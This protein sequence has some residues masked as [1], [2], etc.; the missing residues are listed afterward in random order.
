MPNGTHPQGR[1]RLAELLRLHRT[2][3]D[4]GT[5]DFAKDIGISSATISRIER[6]HAMDAA[7]LM[8]VL[9]WLMQR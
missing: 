2:M 6:G 4:L 7:T 1:T 9:N 8:A 5:R 3:K